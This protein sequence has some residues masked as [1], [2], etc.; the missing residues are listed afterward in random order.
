MWRMA[1]PFILRSTGF[2]FA[3]MERLA[4]PLTFAAT[5]IVLDAEDTVAGLAAGLLEV[6]APIWGSRRDSG[7]R[8]KVLQR[9]LTN[10]QALEPVELATC[11]DDPVLATRLAGWNEAVAHHVAARDAAE[12][13]F[14]EELPAKRA[15]LRE[16]AGDERFK[17]AIFLSSPHMYA[18]G[19]RRFLET[20]ARAERSSDD[21]RHERQITMYLQ[22]FCTKNETTSFFGPI[23]YGRFAGDADTA[24]VAGESWPVAWHQETELGHRE[25]FV[26]YWAVEAMAQAMSKLESVRPHLRP[27]RASTTELVKGGTEIYLPLKN[28]TVRLPE[29]WAATLRLIDG[30]TTVADLV[31]L[32][33]GDIL[34]QLEAR[35]MVRTEVDLPVTSVRPLEDLLTFAL[36]LPVT[37]EIVTWQQKLARLKRLKD[38]FAAAAGPDRKAAS[39]TEAETVFQAAVGLAADREHGKI[40]ADRTLFY[41]ECRSGRE[42]VTVSPAMSERLAR[43]LDPLLILFAQHGVERSRHLGKFGLEIF[44]ELFGNITTRVPFLRFLIA[45]GESPQS[46]DWSLTAAQFESSVQRSLRA[47]LCKSRLGSVLDMEEPI[48]VASAMGDD[49]PA[50]LPLMCSPDIM[51]AHRPDGSALLVLGEIHDTLMLWGWALSFAPDAPLL[52]AEMR[53]FAEGLN[54]DGTAN[55]LTAKRKKIVPFEYPGTSIEFRAASGGGNANLP[56]AALDVVPDGDRL[57]LVVRA[58]GERLRLHNGELPSLAHALFALPRCVPFDLNHGGFTPRLVAGDVVLQR[59]RWRFDRGT[60]GLPPSYNGTK[61]QMFLDMCRLRRREKLPE[62]V[63][64]KIPG[65][66]KPI[67][68]DFRSYF[69]LEAWESLFTAGAPVTVS[70]MLPDRDELWLTDHQGEPVTA[71]LRTGFGR[72]AVQPARSSPITYEAACGVVLPGP[73]P[74][75]SV[76]ASPKT[77]GPLSVLIS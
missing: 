44:R 39:L 55:L 72:P 25:A 45:L 76:F 32:G 47:T 9:K 64:V 26:A 27:R 50:E 11:Q 13:V 10:R 3:W 58:T 34:A 36:G 46:E 35:S 30:A 14:N 67:Y 28:E 52:T 70:E 41:E 23:T 5:E 37:E 59:A 69:L 60:A 7:L 51:I 38:D 43:A 8:W 33:R 68:V 12:R 71:E 63:F 42:Q 77:A 31:R 62:R 49:I 48:R 1:A 2:P 57:E 20:E 17:E 73:V 6:L 29:A 24:D 53:R 15:V 66:P 18:S 75:I 40:Y 16:L 54:L 21:K 22:R 74:A 4:F 56:I 61:Y 19:L 65:E